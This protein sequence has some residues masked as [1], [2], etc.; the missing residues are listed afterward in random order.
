MKPE[1]Q[2]GVAALQWLRDRGWKCYS[3]C[4]IIWG[5]PTDII[6][7]RAGRMLAIELKVGYTKQLSCQMQRKYGSR[8]LGALAEAIAIVG[9]RPRETGQN[10][11]GRVCVLDDQT[12]YQRKVRWG[13]DNPEI[14]W[15]KIEDL[16][17]ERFNNSSTPR[18]VIALM[19][20][21][22]ESNGAGSSGGSKNHSLLNLCL[23]FAGHYPEK[24][25]NL[26][27]EEIAHL[28]HLWISWC[29]KS[30]AAAMLRKAKKLRKMGLT[31]DCKVG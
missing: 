8:G 20:G 2:L 4:E 27:P 30:Y 29:P 15:V 16:V 7:T 19:D 12:L 14:S 31:G 28:M 13:A 9:R 17:R 22:Q 25:V 18:Q 23:N 10:F 26:R 11:I 24:L 1:E 21:E 3:E 5:A 6:A